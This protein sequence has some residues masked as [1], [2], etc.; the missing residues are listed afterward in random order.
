[1]SLVHQQIADNSSQENIPISNGQLIDSNMESA[2]PDENLN[3]DIPL[4]LV[5]SSQD[6]SLNDNFNSDNSPIEEISTEIPEDS[7]SSEVLAN[8]SSLEEPS[9]DDEPLVDLSDSVSL[10]PTLPT[11]EETD[12]SSVMDVESLSISELFVRQDKYALVLDT[13]YS[14]KKELDALI[15][16]CA[17]A[18]PNEKIGDLLS[19]A[20]TKHADLNKKFMFVE[21]KLVS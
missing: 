3:L 6:I 17:L 13:L 2:V 19:K 16:K 12:S 5:D 11:F 4:D 8:N 7:L 14:T 20:T 15:K 18:K 1:M 10:D 21:E 9:F